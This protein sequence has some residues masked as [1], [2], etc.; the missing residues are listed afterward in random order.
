MYS[1]S[2]CHRV[3]SD[4]GDNCSGGQRVLWAETTKIDSFMS[5]SINV[6]TGK[7]EGGIPTAIEN[8]DKGG[9]LRVGVYI[10]Q[11]MTE[12]WSLIHYR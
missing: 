12:S 7:R 8:V 5:V 6:K 10:L 9:H 11:L 3:P 4:I 2:A 1:A